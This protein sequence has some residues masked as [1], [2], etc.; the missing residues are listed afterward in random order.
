[1]YVHPRRLWLITS[2]RLH[3]QQPSC[4][5]ATL[6][7]LSPMSRHPTCH[8]ERLSRFRLMHG[9]GEGVILPRW[10]DVCV[11]STTLATQFM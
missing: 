6:I 9:S 1:M 7:V 11:P 4:S 10:C 3:S 5:C 2:C 8:S